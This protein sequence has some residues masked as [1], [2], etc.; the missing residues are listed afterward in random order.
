MP[1]VVRKRVET[2]VTDY[3]IVIGT[4]EETEE[5]AHQLIAQGYKPWAAPSF[6]NE[7]G[8]VKVCQSFVKKEER[9]I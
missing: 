6:I 8:S 5:K 1:S 7:S 9:I 4:P 3:R 2:I